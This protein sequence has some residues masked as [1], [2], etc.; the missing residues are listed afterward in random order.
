MTAGA[1]RALVTF[2]VPPRYPETGYG[3]VEIGEELSI[4]G[5]RP[6]TPVYRVAQ[7]RENP[8]CPP[9]NAT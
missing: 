6:E 3:Y 4:P 5:L 7:F 8:T 9:P 1:E 2:G